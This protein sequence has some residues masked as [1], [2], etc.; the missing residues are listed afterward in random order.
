M[1]VDYSHWTVYYH[2]PFSTLSSAGTP[3]FTRLVHH[4]VHVERSTYRKILLENKRTLARQLAVLTGELGVLGNG[5]DL[6]RIQL[7]KSSV[8]LG[9]LTSL[10]IV[11]IIRLM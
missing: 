9:S 3:I 6:D 1:S 5:V 8:Y 11:F 2:I 7:A 10:T 4:D